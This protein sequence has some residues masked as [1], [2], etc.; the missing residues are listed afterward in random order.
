ME[1]YKQLQMCVFVS[2]LEVVLHLDQEGQL[3]PRFPPVVVM[4]EQVVYSLVVA[5]KVGILVH[6]TFREKKIFKISKYLEINFC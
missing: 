4:M 5:I 2:Q 6:V 1:S 3:I